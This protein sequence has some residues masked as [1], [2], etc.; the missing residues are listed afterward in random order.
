[1]SLFHEFGHWKYT[2]TMTALCSALFQTAIVLKAMIKYREI[3]NCPLRVSSLFYYVVLT[4]SMFLFGFRQNLLINKGQEGQASYDDSMFIQQTL[5]RVQW[6]ALVNLVFQWIFHEIDTFNDKTLHCPSCNIIMVK[7]VFLLL[8]GPLFL[9]CVLE[10]ESIDP[11]ATLIVHVLVHS[12]VVASSVMVGKTL[13]ATD[14]VIGAEEH[15]YHL[16]AE[17]SIGN[18][19]EDRARFRAQYRAHVMLTQRAGR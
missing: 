6:M 3:T 18:T 15:L 12:K 8:F 19:E 13:S 5:V 14:L 1:M 11:L 7:C 17:G 16:E 2:V 4:A 10:S 9:I